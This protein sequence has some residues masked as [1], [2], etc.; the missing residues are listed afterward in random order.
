[1]AYGL[2]ASVISSVLMP[3]VGVTTGGA[4]L[5]LFL[6]F[7]A[8]EFTIVSLIPLMT[9]VLPKARGTVMAMTIASANLGRGFGSLVA[10]PIFLG[11]FWSISLVAALVNLL[12]IFVLR[13]VVVREDH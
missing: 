1:V 8:F 9:G 5:G 4:Y 11:G 6:Y 2:I 13:Y 10:A 12:A 7:L 3:V